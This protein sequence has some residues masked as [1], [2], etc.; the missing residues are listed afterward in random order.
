M[1]GVY[2]TLDKF[3]IAFI[4]SLLIEANIP[5]FIDN[6][7]ATGIALGRTTGFMTIMVPDSEEKNVKELLKDFI[8][9]KGDN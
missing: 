5:F 3:E 4:K 8:D 1:I 7:N 2:K 6:E 9:R